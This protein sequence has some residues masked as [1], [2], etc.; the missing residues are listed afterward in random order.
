MLSTVEDPSS[1][2][3]V[4]NREHVDLTDFI[5]LAKKIKI[6]QDGDPKCF[7]RKKI[8]RPDGKTEMNKVL[9]EV[10]SFS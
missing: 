5:G 7:S 10:K 8:K 6:Q 3:P 1:C 4:G 2:G 9:K